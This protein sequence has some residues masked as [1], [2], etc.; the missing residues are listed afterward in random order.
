MNPRDYRLH[1]HSVRGVLSSALLGFL[2]IALLGRIIIKLPLEGQVPITLQSMLIVFIPAVIGWKSGTLAVVLYLIAGMLGLPVFAG[3]AS[4]V[5]VFM[6]DSAGFLL[7]FPI[8]AL[9][10]GYAASLDVK[11]TMLWLVAILV[12][13]Q[14]IILASGLFWMEQLHADRFNYRLQFELYA[15]GILLK[16]LMAML[17]A[18]IISQGKRSANSV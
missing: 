15:P 8:V 4:G 7:S 11:M 10:C 12:L 2:M 18:L 16:S 9:L 1:V 17:I 14:L 13:G 5:E 6:G 3:G